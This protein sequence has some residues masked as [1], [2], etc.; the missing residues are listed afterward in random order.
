MVAPLGHLALALLFSGVAR[1]DATADALKDLKAA[2]K[3]KDSA[4]AVRLFDRLVQDWESIA[5]KDKD[6][7]VRVVESSFNSRRDEG[8]E[9]DDL[10]IG[11]AAALAN[12]GAAGEKA[13]VRSLALKHLKSRPMVFATLVEGL[14]QQTNPAMVDQ[15]LPW[16]KPDKPLGVNAP[17]VAGTARALARYREAEPKLRKRVAGELVAVYLDLY[18]RYQTERAKPEPAA[19][20]EAAFQQVEMPM[21]AA[22]RALSG[23]Q[24]EH[25]E[26]WGKWWVTAK[27]QD[28]AAAPAKQE[29]EPKKK[30]DGGAVV[31]HEE[32][33]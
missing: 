25:A 14:G 24:F 13:L 18:G 12:M 17:V 23:E 16:L 26:D 10:F 28:W 29:P 32:L 3:S 31:Q 27:D 8:K 6:E 21:Q 30:S 33:P 4:A 2:Y 7:V 15:L 22:L 1:S 9:V 20:L 11:A 5:A 19:D